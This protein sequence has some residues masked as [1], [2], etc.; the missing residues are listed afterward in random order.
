[1]PDIDD[2]LRN[3]ERIITT[4]G[5]AVTHV[6]PTDD[7]PDTTAPFAY[8]VGLTAHDHPELI[9]AGLPP[10]VAH[11]LLNDLAQ[12]I[13][14]KAERFTHGQRINDLIAD[15]DAII[16]DGRPTEDLLP[17]AAIARYGRH[18]IRLQQIVWPDQQG[19]F[20]WDGGYS[21]D[22]RIQALIAHL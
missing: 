1:M 18:Q 14:D 22:P 4:K 10:L 5:W 21:F 3:Q 8:T 15:Y 12:R 20:P 16:I 13:H 19:Q 6:L 7:D 9:I 17:G 2:F 11:T